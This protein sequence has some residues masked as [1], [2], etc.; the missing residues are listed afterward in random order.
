V[1]VSAVTFGPQVTLARYLRVLRVPELEAPGPPGPSNG[2]C[3]IKAP[4]T[5][6]RS[7]LIYTVTATVTCGRAQAS[8]VART[9]TL[10]TVGPEQL[11][12]T[13]AAEARVPPAE[14]SS[15]PE[16]DSLLP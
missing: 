6:V 4:R 8:E 16:P 12:G 14:A 2:P 13:P 3:L 11:A 1:T 5:V 10:A 9:G 7:R 15:G